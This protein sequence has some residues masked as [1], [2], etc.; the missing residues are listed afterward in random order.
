MSQAQNLPNDVP[1]STEEA[2]YEYVDAVEEFINKSS[3]DII[4]QEVLTNDNLQSHVKMK[5]YDVKTYG[6]NCGQ[7]T[8]LIVNTE[9]YQEQRKIKPEHVDNLKQSI[10]MNKYLMNPISLLV[11]KDV[12]DSCY[13]L[14]DGQHRLK[15]LGDLLYDNPKYIK[16]D[17]IKGIRVNVFHI[18]R[19]IS[20]N[21]NRIFTSFNMSVPSNQISILKYK[22]SHQLAKSINSQFPNTLDLDYLTTTFIKT[23]AFEEYVKKSKQKNV[24]NKN[25]NEFKHPRK[26]WII[27][28]INHIN[29]KYNALSPKNF[30]KTIGIELDDKESINRLRKIDEENTGCRLVMDDVRFTWVSNLI[31][32]LVKYHTN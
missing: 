17:S 24:A 4:D 29:E 28:E 26:K 22:F 11:I 23:N 16:N 20:L 21:L 19:R 5:D 18:W 8:C 32:K 25:P 6:L 15:A 3:K 27:R 30:L 9:T 12:T 10:D 2:D 7:V 31:N 14:F 13:L 1:L